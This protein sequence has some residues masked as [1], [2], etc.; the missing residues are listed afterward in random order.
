MV[1]V[2]RYRDVERALRAAAEWRFAFPGGRLVVLSDA[3]RQ[4]G[5]SFAASSTH[6]KSSPKYG[7]CP[8][9][10]FICRSTRSE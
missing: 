6:R 2:M 7:P 1:R 9:V 5:P 8:S 3:R 10:F 4:A